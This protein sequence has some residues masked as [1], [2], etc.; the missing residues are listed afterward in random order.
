MVI[1]DLAELGDQ[2][3]QIHNEL[4]DFIKD[5]DINLLLSHGVMSRYT[6]I[7]CGGRHFD[8]LKD[9][10]SELSETISRNMDSNCVTNIL[11]KGSRSSKMERVV[12]ALLR[13]YQI[14]C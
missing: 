13:S 3:C 7:S 1:G 5:S 10:L 12:Q 8:K 11:V 2:S 9:L 6:S 4:G 14:P